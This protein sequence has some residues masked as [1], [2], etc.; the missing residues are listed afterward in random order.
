VALLSIVVLLRIWART[1]FRTYFRTQILWIRTF[2][3]RTLV[4][5][6]FAFHT[7]VF[8]TQIVVYFRAWTWHVGSRVLIHIFGQIGECIFCRMTLR[9][10]DRILLRIFHQVQWCTVSGRTWGTRS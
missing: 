6:N 5:R 3:F 10:F 1:L 7:S 8:R 4:F 9:I 2:V